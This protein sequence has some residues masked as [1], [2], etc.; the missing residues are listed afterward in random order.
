M[1][2]NQS[3]LI[4]AFSRKYTQGGFN[5]GFAEMLYFAQVGQ[6]DYLVCSVLRVVSSHVTP[7]GDRGK[8][9]S[10]GHVKSVIE[11]IPKDWRVGPDPV[12]CFS[13]G[14]KKVARRARCA[15]AVAAAQDD[16]EEEQDED[17]E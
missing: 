15:E 9:S 8:V 6:C 1:D 13:F 16:D 10:D 14:R 7:T 11:K 12:L 2:L 17:V 4:E 5:S 3:D